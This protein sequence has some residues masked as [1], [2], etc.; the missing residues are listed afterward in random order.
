MAQQIVIVEMETLAELV[1]QFVPPKV[2][3]NRQV[4][5]GEIVIV[6]NNNP[7][8]HYTSGTDELS[9]NLSFHAVEQNRED[10]LNAVRWLRSLCYND[11]L[12][13]ER[14]KL[15]IIWGNFLK[16]ELWVL[17]SVRPELQAIDKVHGLVPTQAFVAV[18][19][20]LQ[21]KKNLLR[22]DVRGR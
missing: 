13:S 3:W 2:S 21:P 12:D 14:P 19:F 6:G 17:S 15:K 5:A 4:K 8:E 10:A 11:G 9:F 20:K 7:I 1:I 16:E 22:K 18:T